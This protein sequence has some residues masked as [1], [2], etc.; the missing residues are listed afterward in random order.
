[1]VRVGVRLQAIVFVFHGRA[2]AKNQVA[3]LANIVDQ[4]FRGCIGQHIKSGRDNQLVLAREA[5]GSTTST[6][7][8][9]ARSGP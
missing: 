3:A 4:I 9:M 7:W 2:L 6:D 1:M 5:T 8:L